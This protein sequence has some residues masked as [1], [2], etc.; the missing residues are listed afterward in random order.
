M[1]RPEKGT[2]ENRLKGGAIASSWKRFLLKYRSGKLKLISIFSLLAV[3]EHTGSIPRSNSEIDRT[4]YE[5][6]SDP[7]S[8]VWSTVF[9]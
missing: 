5:Q 1:M 7:E 3:F 2:P 8:E 9:P 6:V 4:E